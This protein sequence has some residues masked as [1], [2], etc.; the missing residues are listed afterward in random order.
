MGFLRMGTVFLQGIPSNHILVCLLVLKRSYSEHVAQ[1]PMHCDPPICFDFF[2][3]LSLS[4]GK[5][6]TM[7]TDVIAGSEDCYLNI[8]MLLNLSHSMSYFRIQKDTD[9]RRG[10]CSLA[11]RTGDHIQRCKIKQNSILTFFHF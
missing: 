10:N 8:Q 7:F 5:L 11:Q 1:C 9:C 6:T 2:S 4:V 3:F